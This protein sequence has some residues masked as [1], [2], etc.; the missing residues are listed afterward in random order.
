MDDEKP[1]VAPLD[2]EFAGRKVWLV[3]V[4]ADVHRLQQNQT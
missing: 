1:A 4:G 3:K 2:T